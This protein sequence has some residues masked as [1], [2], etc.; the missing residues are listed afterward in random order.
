MKRLLVLGMLCSVCSTHA[1]VQPFAEL[2][3]DVKASV[4][5]AIVV[6]GQRLD[7]PWV[8]G[9]ARGRSGEETGIGEGIL[10]VVD[11]PD[12]HEGDGVR[13]VLRSGMFDAS[14]AR[15]EVN[16]SVCVDVIFEPVGDALI[17]FQSLKLNGVRSVGIFVSPHRADAVDLGNLLADGVTVLTA[18]DKFRVNNK[19]YPCGSYIVTNSG[20]ESFS[21][22]KC[23]A[24]R[25]SVGPSLQIK[26]PNG[27]IAR[28]FQV[29]SILSAGWDLSNG[30]DSSFEIWATTAIPNRRESDMEYYFD[31]EG[32]YRGLEEFARL[33]LP[34][35]R[36]G[37]LIGSFGGF[38]HKTLDGYVGNFAN[39]GRVSVE[40]IQSCMRRLKELYVKLQNYRE[41]AP[42]HVDA[43][44]GGLVLN[45]K[46]QLTGGQTYRFSL[47]E[48][49]VEGLV[50]D[51]PPPPPPSE[52]A[53]Q[54]LTSPPTQTLTSRGENPPGPVPQQGEIV[55]D[56]SRLRG[57]KSLMSQLSSKNRTLFRMV[58]DSRDGKVTV[59]AA[60][61]ERLGDDI[62]HQL[63][64]SGAVVDSKA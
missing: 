41:R 20:M 17:R 37:R 52:A 27:E 48:G 6:A 62:R 58:R 7:G 42:E 34:H 14:R 51:G 53:S 49:L 24:A 46:G 19:L 64:N 9:I 4:N 35:G 25:P 8:S 59:N 56:A 26:K 1:A 55:V 43:L 54:P 12:V 39:E 23:V 47:D 21:I 16:T 44:M 13:R 60:E 38:V 45:E 18:N 57:N 3:L 28:T 10:L 50:A 33:V 31:K 30:I 32:A 36:D 2:R 22:E 29:A 63:R 5:P 11:D 61:L 15:V 40:P